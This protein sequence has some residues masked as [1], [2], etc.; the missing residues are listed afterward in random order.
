MLQAKEQLRSVL[1]VDESFGYMHGGRER[2]PTED[3]AAMSVK[4]RELL[5]VRNNKTSFIDMSMTTTHKQH[6]QRSVLACC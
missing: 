1:G 6:K 2:T 3:I 4:M 5:H